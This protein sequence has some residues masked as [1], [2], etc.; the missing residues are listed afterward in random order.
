M[1]YF[2]YYLRKL[3]AYYLKCHKTDALQITVIVNNRYK[4]GPYFLFWGK[5]S[6]F[7]MSLIECGYRRTILKKLKNFRLHYTT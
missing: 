1:I 4:L 6:L 7:K 2:S 3:N 5:T